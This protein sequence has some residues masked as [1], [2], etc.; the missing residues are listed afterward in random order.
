M[1]LSRR[2]LIGAGAAAGALSFLP[3]SAS[4]AP[5]SQMPDWQI[6]YRTAPAGGF[7]PAKMRTV[8]GKAPA[9]LSGTL[10]RNG[11]GPVQLWRYI[12]LSLV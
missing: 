12:C 5:D 7:G 8:F 9:D 3:N 11:P 10:Y 4:A 2:T 6:G 1:E